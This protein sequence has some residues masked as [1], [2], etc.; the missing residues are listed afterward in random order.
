[1]KKLFIVGFALLVL[2]SSLLVPTNIVHAQVNR[3]DVESWIIGGY[4]VD[5]GDIWDNPAEMEF[6]R[7]VTNNVHYNATDPRIQGWCTMVMNRNIFP[8]GTAQGHGTWITY[9]ESFS[10]GYWAGTFTAS[11]DS[12]GDMHVRMVGK[13]YGTLDGLT[14]SGSLDGTMMSK[15]YGV[16]TELPTYSP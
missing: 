13:G 9:P 5:E 16:I 2:V 10:D 11:I 4:P 3:V 15:V 14:Y 12:A 7:G 8:D 6:W 1:M